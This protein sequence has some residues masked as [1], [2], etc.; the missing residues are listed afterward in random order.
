MNGRP[1]A[2]SRPPG[3]C[4]TPPNC[5]GS[6]PRPTEPAGPRR[7]A[8]A[9]DAPLPAGGQELREL[10]GKANEGDRSV[11]P[12]V[13]AL[14]RTVPEEALRLFG[15]ELSIRGLEDSSAR[16]T[17]NPAQQA[18][19]RT[20]LQMLRADLEGPSATAIEKVLAEQAVRC[21]LQAQVAD[22]AVAEAGEA[23]VGKHRI[24]LQRQDQAHRRLTAAL[25]SLATVRRLALPALKLHIP[26]YCPSATRCRLSEAHLSGRFLRTGLVDGGVGG[27]GG[28][29][30]RFRRGGGRLV[31]EVGRVRFLRAGA[32]KAGLLLQRLQLRRQQSES[33]HGAV[34]IEVDGLKGRHGSGKT[35]PGRRRVDEAAHLAGQF[36]GVQIA[37]QSVPTRQIADGAEDDGRIADALPTGP[38]ERCGYVAG[39]FQLVPDVHEERGIRGDRGRRQAEAGGDDGG[40]GAGQQARVDNGASMLVL[41]SEPQV[42]GALDVGERVVR[43]GWCGA[44]VLAAPQQ[45]AEAAPDPVVVEAADRIGRQAEQQLDA[46]PAVV[47]GER[48][49]CGHGPSG[50]AFPNGSHLQGVRRHNE[51]S[52]AGTGDV[53][54]GLHGRAGGEAGGWPVL[55]KTTSWI[56]LLCEQ[57]RGGHMQDPASEKLMLV[58]DPRMQFV[59][60]APDRRW[61]QAGAYHRLVRKPSRCADPDVPQGLFVSEDVE[62]G[63]QAEAGRACPCRT[64][65]CMVPAGSTPRSL[66]SAGCWRPPSWPALSIA[67]AAGFCGVSEGAARLYASVFFDVAGKLDSP[68]W[69][70][71]RLPLLGVGI[72]SVDLDTTYKIIGYTAGWTVLREYIGFAKTNPALRQELTKMIHGLLLKLGK[73]AAFRVEINDRNAVELVGQC[74]KLIRQ[75]MRVEAARNAG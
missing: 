48:A 9:P 69:I 26:R 61:K 49:K 68:G 15:G 63:P 29:G 3:R 64:R 65:T 10:V 57:D 66:R 72:A 5:A 51:F 62:D 75:R 74:G 45:P 27:V 58:D 32:G 31:P 46:L 60:D 53:G 44:V 41:G 24:L 33:P 11:L 43:L 8:R 12:R 59:S 36:A 50:V 73:L 25:K 20:K 47:R 34:G 40:V 55:M 2:P 42:V 35:L 30:D 37:A 18:A 38:E 67:E 54:R 52:R 39:G 70:M 6:S 28:V 19:I 56:V 16:Y 22:R 17:N 71:S 14:L 13:R 1:P 7:K 21:W 4:G 23:G